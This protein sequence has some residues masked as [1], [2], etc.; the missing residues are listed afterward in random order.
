MFFFFFP[1]SNHVWMWEDEEGWALKN[2]CLWT[3]VLER[4]LRVPWAARRSN[5]SVLKEITLNIIGRTD[6]ELKLQYFCHLMW[7][8]NSLGKTP[9][10][11][12]DWRWEKKGMT[13][14]EMVRWDPWFNGD[15]FEQTPGDSEEHGIL[16]CCSPG[17]IE[18]QTRLRDWITTRRGFQLEEVLLFSKF[19]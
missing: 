3:V 13:E 7:R 2:W 15:E 18:S 12:K 11:G 19:A 4:L 16:A 8:T 5:Q 14:D 9:S 6:T 17:V 10:A 1:S